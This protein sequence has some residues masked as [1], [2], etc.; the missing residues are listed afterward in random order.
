MHRNTYEIEQLI[1][2]IGHKH[3][4]GCLLSFI[5]YHQN[6][7]SLHEYNIPLGK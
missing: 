4:T 2:T 7:I 6:L 5:S 3:Y 1:T